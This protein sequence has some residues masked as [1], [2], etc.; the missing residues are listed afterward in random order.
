M[1][2]TSI[3]DDSPFGGFSTSTCMGSA[4]TSDSELFLPASISMEAA[5][6]VVMDDTIG[7]LAIEG[8][9]GRIDFA[10]L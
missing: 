9:G 1:T 7:A 6:L 8:A 10:S 4:V 5:S 3:D 2:A